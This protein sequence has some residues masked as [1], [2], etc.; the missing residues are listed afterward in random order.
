[1]NI[2][3]SLVIKYLDP[4]RLQSQIV[5]SDFNVFRYILLQ[6]K[7]WHIMITIVNFGILINIELSRD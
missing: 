2:E 7:P 4:I 6:I 5:P 1:M 3:I